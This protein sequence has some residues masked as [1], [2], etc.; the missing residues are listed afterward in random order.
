MHATIGWQGDRVVI[1][2][3][4]TARSSS[5]LPADLSF[6]LVGLGFRPPTPEEEDRFRHEIWGATVTRQLRV[7]PRLVWPAGAL[8]HHAPVTI[9]L[10]DPCPPTIAIPSDTESDVISMHGSSQPGARL[11]GL[12]SL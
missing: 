3:Y 8:L 9:D 4:S 12:C 10:D 6:K 1:A 7:E 11:L 5:M 2:A